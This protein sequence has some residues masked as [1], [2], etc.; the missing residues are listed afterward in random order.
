MKHQPLNKLLR[1]LVALPLALWVGSASAMPLAL[2]TFDPGENFDGWTGVECVNPGLCPL[3]GEVGS[4]AAD[5]FFHDT[6]DPK[7]GEPGIGYLEIEDPL[8]GTTGL[9][10]APAKF[11]DA[12]APGTVLNYDMKIFGGEFDNG[13]SDDVPILY[14]QS[15]SAAVGLLYV[16]TESDL[17]IGSWFEMTV[18]IVP[19]GDPLAG[20]GA[21]FGFT[22]SGLS[23]TPD[24][25]TAFAAT[26]G[27]AGTILRI[28]GE[29][30]KDDLDIDGTRL[31]NVS[32]SAIPIPAALP[33]ML[34]A[35]GMFGL[36]RRKA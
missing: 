12:L 14:I 19:N 7:P 10:N 36:W 21:W 13:T 15:T 2:S 16:V 1:S 31:D 28:L 29:L 17:P 23:P 33:M 27:G 34:S 18:P 20:A 22:D 6:A 26:F 24:D 35:I 8:S 4:L 25:G 9:Y 32:L 30:T 5:K 11:T 3:F